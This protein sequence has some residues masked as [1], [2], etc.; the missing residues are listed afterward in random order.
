MVVCSRGPVWPATR[1]LVLTGA[2]TISIL[3]RGTPAHSRR[4]A[5]GERV[6]SKV[7]GRRAD[8][9]LHCA[10]TSLQ[11]GSER[12]TACDVMFGGLRWLAPLQGSPLAGSP[13]RDQF[14]PDIFEQT[15]LISTQS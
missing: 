8:E 13:V 9:A 1:E 12:L 14:L 11:W 3:G 5:T 4:P 6:G 10:T 7:L 15:L 2:V